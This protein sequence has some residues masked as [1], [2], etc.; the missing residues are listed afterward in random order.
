MIVL[1]NTVH[2]QHDLMV[3]G[4]PLTKKSE[5]IKDLVGEG[6]ENEPV[7]K[8]P[9]NSLQRPEL[10]EKGSALLFICANAS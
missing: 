10:E 6:R 8:D 9:K 7:K 2:T 1:L 4:R 3:F 5:A